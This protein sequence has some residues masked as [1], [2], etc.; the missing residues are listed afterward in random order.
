MSFPL[1]LCIFDT[2]RK[3]CAHSPKLY[4][5]LLIFMIYFMLINS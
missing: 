5:I 1:R 2:S 4:L 3:A